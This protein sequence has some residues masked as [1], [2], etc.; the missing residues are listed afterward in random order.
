[1]KTLH[2]SLFLALTVLL[3]V[4]CGPSNPERINWTPRLD[5]D[6]LERGE[7]QRRQQTVNTV[8]YQ[9]MID[10][11]QGDEQ[12]SGRVQIELD[13]Q[14]APFPL[15]VDFSGGS[16]QSLAI[17]GVAV[18]V[19]YNNYFLNI[20]P[21]SL[22]AGGNVLDISF[23]QSYSKDGE[24]LYRYVDPEDQRVYLCTDFE[25][26]AASRL[27]PHFDQPDLKARFRLEVLAPSSC[28]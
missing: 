19:D 14:P 15:T 2:H 1:M 26:Y 10:L 22:R 7:A 8:A 5:A 23:S 4:G 12:F 24:G 25:P 27:F 13:Y 3:I 16:I 18:E 17:N 9:L 11:N 20:A 28:R 21:Q 6:L